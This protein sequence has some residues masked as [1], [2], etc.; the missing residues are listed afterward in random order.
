MDK[1]GTNI[2]DDYIFLTLIDEKIIHQK[3][4]LLYKLIM[5]KKNSN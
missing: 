3:K 4:V 5:Q 2:F 1:G